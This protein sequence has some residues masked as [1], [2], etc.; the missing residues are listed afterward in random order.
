MKVSVVIPCFNG[1][2]FVEKAVRSVL[3]QSHADL[4][5]IVV[6]DAST[7][8][9]PLVLKRL[10][11]ADPRVVVLTQRS[12]G[13]ASRARNLGL[14]AA[15]GD[16]VTVLDA[17]DLYQ[18]DRLAGLL[19]LATATEADVVV[20]NQSVRW[21]PDGGHLYAA[22][23]FL[24]GDQPVAITQETFFEHSGSSAASL[25]TGFMK[26]MIRRDFLETHE[27]RYDPRLS[28]GEDFHLFA[29][30]MAR[31]PRFFGTAAATYVYY[32][33]R[34]SL[35]FA[36]VTPLR[37][38]AALTRELVAA[39]RPRLSPRSIA[40]AEARAGELDAMAEVSDFSRALKAGRICAAVAAL[41]RHPRLA[42]RLPRVLKQA[43]TDRLASRRSP[44]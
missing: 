20:D 3:A 25:S 40:L 28:V 10:A 41:A 15:T 22:F 32:R 11:A 1:A 34:G 6:D 5:C 23:S 18:P 31:R 9:S 26:P 7:D 44:A 14:D 30:M 38:M 16:F 19:A 13:G 27:L 4:E 2:A 35:S 39:E 12:N 8:A 24:T 33:R 17:D 29:R 43:L 42:A 21:Y 36:G 37:A